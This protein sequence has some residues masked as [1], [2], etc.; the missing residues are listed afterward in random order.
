MI[1]V[2]KI[3]DV[4][5]HIWAKFHAA[6]LPAAKKPFYLKAVRQPELDIHDVASK[7]EVYNMTTSPQ[8]IEEGLNAGIELMYYLAAD[9]FNIKTPLFRL[10]VR[11]PGE[12]DGIE[13]CLPPGVCAAPKLQ[14]SPAFRKYLKE[15]VT[16]GI[17]GIYGKEGRIAIVKDEATGTENEVMT[18]G[19]ILTIHGSGL[20]IDGD[21][22]QRDQVGLFF[23]P[24][25]GEP[26]KAKIVSLNNARTLMALVPSELKAGTAY[27]LTVET[28]SSAKGYGFMLKNIRTVNSDFTL[29]AQNQEETTMSNTGN[30]PSRQAVRSTQQ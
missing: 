20:K 26:I 23:T 21:A 10:R 15:K 19:S 13:T 11:I 9:G 16:I 28:R 12:Y 25:D 1:T 18:I 3:N 2:F 7:A 27:S 14:V 5:H 22:E 30:S 8:V 24:E 17:D 4:M 6:Y 29:T